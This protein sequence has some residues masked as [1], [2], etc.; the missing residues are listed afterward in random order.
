[1]VPV[2]ILSG[3]V[4]NEVTLLHQ[5]DR[6]TKHPSI[7]SEIYKRERERRILA[8]EAKLSDT[9]RQTS[10]GRTIIQKK[11][12]FFFLFPRE[13]SQLEP[14]FETPRARHINMERSTKINKR[15]ANQRRRRRGEWFFLWLFFMVIL[16]EMGRR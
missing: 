8:I 11:V 15:T 7:E 12:R 13:G 5:P 3:R 16:A 14:N 2:F 1:M 4:Q 6:P 10:R 9:R